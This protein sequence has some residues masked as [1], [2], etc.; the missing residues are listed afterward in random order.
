VKC[1]TQTIE[2]G[3]KLKCYARIADQVAPFVNYG[4]GATATIT[5]SRIILLSYMSDIY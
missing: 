2:E 5:A 1:T 4:N 3:S